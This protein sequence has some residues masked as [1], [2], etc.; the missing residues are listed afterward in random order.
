M[1][2]VIDIHSK[3]ELAS[4]SVKCLKCDHCWHETLAINEQNPLILCPICAN[5]TRT[6]KIIN[7]R[8]TQ[9]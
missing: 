1:G 7:K 8:G 2:K 6:F 4:I 5:I 3:E 9:K